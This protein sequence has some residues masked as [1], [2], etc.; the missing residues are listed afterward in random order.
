MSK[1][2]RLQFVDHGQHL[3]K[4]HISSLCLKET[5]SA[6]GGQTGLYSGMPGI[7]LPDEPFAHSSAGAWQ[8]LKP[9]TG[10]SGR[11]TFQELWHLFAA[12]PTQLQKSPDWR[13]TERCPPSG[14]SPSFLVPVASHNHHIILSMILNVTWACLM[15]AQVFYFHASCKIGLAEFAPESN[16]ISGCSFP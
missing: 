16:G 8:P 12:W 4:G 1:R 10:G 6:M 2:L 3:S 7:N 11:S 14:V 5:S 13:G 9:A 15:R